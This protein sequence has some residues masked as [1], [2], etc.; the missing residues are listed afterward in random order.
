MPN[1]PNHCRI[2]CLLGLLFSAAAH[3]DGPDAPEP[4]TLFVTGSRDTLFVA[5]HASAGRRDPRTRIA[6]QHKGRKRYLPIDS[7]AGRLCFLVAGGTRVYGFFE[8]GRVYAYWRESAA[9]A[10]QYAVRATLPE[11]KRPI[12]VGVSSSGSALWAIVRGA[13][14][15]TRPSPEPS[16]PL[17]ATPPT[18]PEISRFEDDPSAREPVSGRSPTD[19]GIAGRRSYRLISLTT[20]G[21]SDAGELPKRLQTHVDFH[22]C[23]ASGSVYILSR[24]GPDAATLSVDKLTRGRWSS[25]GRLDIPSGQCRVLSLAPVNRRPYAVFTEPIAA[26]DDGR[27]NV[28]VV[29][30]DGESRVPVLLPAAE[31]GPPLVVPREAVAAATAFGDSVVVAYAPARDRVTVGRWRVNGTVIR[32]PSELDAF[33]P[34]PLWERLLAVALPVIPIIVLI[35]AL[36]Y[37]WATKR[38][39]I[40]KPAELPPG[41]APAPLTRRV[42]ALAIDASPAVAAAYLIWWVCWDELPG[43]SP[44][45]GVAT[46]ADAT[47]VESSFFDTVICIFYGL[48]CGAAELVFRTTPGKRLLKMRVT[49]L[50]GQPA[51]PRQFLIRNALR[52]VEVSPFFLLAMPVFPLLTVNRQRVGDVL[53][54]TMVVCRPTD[55][56]DD[57]HG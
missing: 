13:P 14:P 35:A 22:L 55:P 57:P 54:D 43:L 23:A 17:S 27:A 7:F 12:A 15:T 20:A 45:W 36:T 37:I 18:G 1:H 53:A 26:Q 28:R 52:L 11:E 16:V 51:G 33:T 49:S 24:E 32:A 48:Y 46:G 4:V 41:L 38:E 34:R 50:D 21:W 10:S 6:L 40:T 42:F 47:S 30:V 3:A 25:P 8:G 39:K 5:E 44:L 56:G 29:L 19:S 9:N 31:G 2:V